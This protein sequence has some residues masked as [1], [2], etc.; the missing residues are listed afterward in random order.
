MNDIIKIA[1][2]QLLPTG[3]QKG[4]MEKGIEYCKKARLSGADIAVF[5]EMW[6]NGYEVSH[7]RSVNM[8]NAVDEDSE[9]VKAFKAIAAELEMAVG[10][11]FLESCDDM[12]KNT[13]VLFDR[14]GRKV[15]HYSKVHTCDFDVEANLTPGDGFRVCELDTAAGIVKVGAMICYDRE[16]PESARLLMLDGAEVVLTPNAC[17]MEIN[18]ISQLRA[19][20]FE[21]MMAIATVNYPCGQPD[22][23]G[24]STVFD[25]IVYRPD[26]PSSRDTLLV[27]AG[28]GE[29]IYIAPINLTE[30]RAYRALEVH[31]NAYRRPEI[32]GKLVS[33]EVSEP[34]IRQRRNAKMISEL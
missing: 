3:T 2:M 21:N 6:N 23:N 17:P 12:P 30:L 19:R 13:F 10:I 8:T 14:F 20:A 4:N 33:A 25:G 31:G 22:C 29:G 27:E 16:F 32:Y 9:F 18:R 26:E 15:L 7:D 5:P 28:D 1:L 11:T 24:H 34:F